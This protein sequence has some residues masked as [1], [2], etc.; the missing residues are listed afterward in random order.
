MAGW[1]DG[2]IAQL[3][4]PTRLGR[5]AR[6]AR[7]DASEAPLEP[8]DPPPPSI[9]ATRPLAP[10]HPASLMCVCVCVCVG[11]MRSTRTMIRGGLEC[12]RKGIGWGFKRGEGTGG[13]VESKGT[14]GA[15]QVEEGGRAEEEAGAKG[16]GRGR[17]GAGRKEKRDGQAQKRMIEAQ[18]GQGA[19]EKP[20]ARG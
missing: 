16:V 14:S 18:A 8:S 7:P 4:L 17:W 13:V 6:F 11:V 15:S 12:K 9:G 10:S 19:S 3:T 20:A 2:R 5:N 1:T